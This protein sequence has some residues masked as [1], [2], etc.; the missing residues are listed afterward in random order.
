MQ[1][2]AD[3][4]EFW[5]WGGSSGLLNNSG[6]GPLYPLVDL[7]LDAWARWPSLAE[8]IHKGGW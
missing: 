3:P 8:A 2:S 1:A 7:I 4:I 6:A 5:S